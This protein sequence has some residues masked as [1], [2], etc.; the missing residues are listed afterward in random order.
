MKSKIS[1]IIISLI[2][3]IS[4]ISGLVFSHNFNINEE[5]KYTADNSN[6]VVHEN[7]LSMML[8]TES[9]SGKYEM[10]TRSDWPTDGYIFNETLSKCENGG[11]LSWDD[12]K[13]LVTMTGGI[14][15]KCYAYFDK[16]LTLA[17]Y[18]KS[19]YTSTQ[20]ENGLYYHD[21]TLENGI[22]DGSYRYAGASSDVDNY[23]CISDEETCSDANLFRIIGVFAEGVK[24]IK[25]ASIGNYAW[26]SNNSNVWANSSLNTY[27]NGDYLNSLG[28]FAINNIATTTWKVGGNSWENIGDVIPVTTYTNEI[29]SP[30]ASSTVSKK[31]G[32]M[33]ASDYG[34]AAGSTAW[35][36]KLGY[37]SVN[38]YSNSAV[39][40]INWLYLGSTE[41]LIIH[42]SDRSGRG[43]DVSSIGYVNNSNNVTA[44]FAVRPVFYLTASVK[45]AS[46]SGTSDNPIRLS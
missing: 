26:D 25:A 19:L 33:Y 3:V 13:K 28:D 22:N 1:Y 36:R 4:I 41:W 46:G 8:E 44:I 12:E 9:G 2:F 30:A 18:V 24:L 35:S 38:G 34:F 20:G 10:V 15:D 7:T 45:Y 39:T 27:L 40:A 32:L 23:V 16:V 42:V 5:A 29:I 37:D 31:I 14:S 11:K 43:F 21:G 6:Q 17:S